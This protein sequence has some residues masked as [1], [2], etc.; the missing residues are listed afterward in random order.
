[1]PDATDTLL[2]E[3]EIM[4][5]ACKTMRYTIKEGMLYLKERGRGVSEASY[6]E[7]VRKISSHTEERMFEITKNFK[8]M[9]MDRIDSLKQVEKELWDTYRSPKKVMVP[10][11]TSTPVT[12]EATG[13]TTNR[14][15][16]VMIPK[17][18]PLDP[19]E[20]VAIL[21]SISDIQPWI[22]SYEESTKAV[23]EDAIREFGSAQQQQQI[24]DTTGE[25]DLYLPDSRG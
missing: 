1:M 12:D 3:T 21:K 20:K 16:T 8:Q 14:T 7:A 2:T 6:R 17:E 18:V 9:H 23:M 11:K 15:T 22:S 25:A 10:Q 4:I 24:G 13:K 5:L 19:K